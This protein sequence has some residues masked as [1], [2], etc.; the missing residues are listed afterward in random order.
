MRGASEQAKK[1][2]RNKSG[3]FVRLP[4]SAKKKKLVSN[5][6]QREPWTKED[7]KE[8]KMLIKENTPT[9]VIGLKLGRTVE[10]IEAEVAKEGLSL[11]PRNQSPYG[12]R[13]ARKH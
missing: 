4:E 6:N 1:M 12:S 2:V 11:K 9:R 7:L 13:L 10:S 3:E 8:L 5:R